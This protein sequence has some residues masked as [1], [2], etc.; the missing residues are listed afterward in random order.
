MSQTTLS[1][2]ESNQLGGSETEIK[3]FAK[4]F[5]ITAE[6]LKQAPSKCA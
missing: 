1:K 2:I 6:A 5:E 3:Q 4:I